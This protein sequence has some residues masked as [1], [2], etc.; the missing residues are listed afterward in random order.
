MIKKSKYENFTCEE[1]LQ[2]RSLENKLRDLSSI[3]LNDQEINFITYYRNNRIY[4]FLS[5]KILDNTADIYNVIV[6]EKVQNKGVAQQMFYELNKYN[7]ILEVKSTNNNAI[8][9]YR[10]LEM[11]KIREIKNYYKDSTDAWVFYKENKK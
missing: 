9:L 5:Y 3:Y 1:K 6:D 7:L 4:G 2:I 10:K 8:N 11:Q